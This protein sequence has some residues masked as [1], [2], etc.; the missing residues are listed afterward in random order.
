MI[1]QLNAAMNEKIKCIDDAK[2]SDE[3]AHP[4]DSEL[5]S[6]AF[7]NI[8]KA[9]VACKTPPANPSAP[10]MNSVLGLLQSRDDAVDRRRDRVGVSNCHDKKKIPNAEAALCFSPYPSRFPFLVESSALK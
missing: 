1:N 7:G 3:A 2:T 9:L 5:S 10:D 8:L 6:S 4:S